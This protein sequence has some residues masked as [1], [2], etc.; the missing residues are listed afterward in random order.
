M[1]APD[2]Y[3][4]FMSK[5]DLIATVKQNLRDYM[6]DFETLMD[7]YRSRVADEAMHLRDQAVMGADPLDLSV[8]SALP[9]PVSHAEDYLAALRTLVNP[10]VPADDKI[11]MPMGLFNE[12]VLDAWP[13][14]EEFDALYELYVEPDADVS[15]ADED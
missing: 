3:H 8:L 15:E 11:G 2:P 1:N 12:L 13:W 7:G 5:A 9:V 4:V 14:A 6:E 10:A